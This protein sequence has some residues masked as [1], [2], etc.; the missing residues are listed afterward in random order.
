MTV[1][2]PYSV[3]QYKEK[4]RILLQNDQWRLLSSHFSLILHNWKKVVHPCPDL[5]KSIPL[6]FW[7][8]LLTY[9]ISEVPKPGLHQAVTVCAA[10]SSLTSRRQDFP[11]R[12]L[13]TDPSLK[14]K[15]H[16]LGC[17]MI[18]TVRA[19]KLLNGS[20]PSK[21]RK[22]APAMLIIPFYMNMF[23]QGILNN[24]LN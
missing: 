4:S 19:T 15:P 11:G 16:L 1:I 5:H 24:Y 21:D 22:K 14:I 8:Y 3:L 10:W 23:F 17:E 7:N 2:I 13:Q 12:D 18:I 20:D 9:L 6:L